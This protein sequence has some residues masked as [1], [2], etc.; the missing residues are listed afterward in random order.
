M[1]KHKLVF[2]NR[3]QFPDAQV[4]FGH[5]SI[6][7]KSKSLET[8]G[9]IKS[10]PGFSAFNM[11][12]VVPCGYLNCVACWRTS[13]RLFGKVTIQTHVSRTVVLLRKSSQ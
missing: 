8:K 5:K 2:Q 9:A 12:T 6:L 3:N 7:L 13:P 1:D 11:A 10:F 4:N